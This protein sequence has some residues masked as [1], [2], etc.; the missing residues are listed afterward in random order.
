MTATLTAFILTAYFGLLIVISFLTSRK[1]DNEAFFSANRQSPWF[2]V[3]FGMIGSSISGVTFISVPALVNTAHFS[4]LQLIFGNLVG[5]WLI[6][7]VLLPLYYR[8][9]LISIYGYFAQRFGKYSHKT[10]AIIFLVSRLAGSSARLFLA[11]M[12]LQLFL[13]EQLGVP[14]FVTTG[15]ALGLIWLYTFK[16]GIKTIIWTDTI[17]T[18]FLLVAVLLTILTISNALQLNFW[19]IPSV[20]NEHPFSETLFW[21]WNDKRNF[22]KNF[23]AGIF[24][25]VAM[26]G[27]DQDMMQKN[28]TCRSLRQS[29]KNMFVLGIIYVP[30]NLLFLSLGVLLYIFAEKNQI[31]LPTVADQ[32]Y[33]ILAKSYLGVGTGILFLLGIT[34]AAYSSADSA[35]TALTTSFCKDILKFEDQLQE[36]KTRQWVHIG[37]TVL[38]YF[39]IVLFKELATGDSQIIGLILKMAG[40]TYAPLLGL[41]LVGLYTSWQLHE[42]FV[43]FIVLLAPFCSYLLDHFVPI[44]LDYRFGFELGIVNTLLTV[45][46]LWI[47]RKP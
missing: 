42:K 13:F 41:F 32:L 12:V 22:W 8:L 5:Y 44:Y 7:L 21:D 3:T 14:F 1:I 34:A 15:F 31:T 19:Q 29:Q 17:Q 38:S 2:L 40:Y 25:T 10:A 18:A 33:P 30:V 24:V 28:L 43:P 37:F 45:L 47:I 26:T 39:M 23:A 20:I 4:Y 16:G 46:G 35:L 11:A 6:A 27:I 9:N 36:S